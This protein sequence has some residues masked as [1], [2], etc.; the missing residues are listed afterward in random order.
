MIIFH[1]VN[2]YYTA[3]KNTLE[4]MSVLC[5]AG[6]QV[7][8]EYKYILFYVRSTFLAVPEG[9]IECSEEST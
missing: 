2:H 4:Y 9:I 3:I 1:F 5:K 6:K 7:K 8:K